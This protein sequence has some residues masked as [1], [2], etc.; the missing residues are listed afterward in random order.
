MASD[1][2]CSSVSHQ[3]MRCWVGEYAADP[4]GLRSTA[5]CCIRC[6]RAPA[7]SVTARRRL[8]CYFDWVWSLYL[9]IRLRESAFPLAFC[10]APTG[11]TFNCRFRTYI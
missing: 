1:F 11:L 5:R 2:V 8:T 3:I 9:A 10:R 4:M 6:L 7:S